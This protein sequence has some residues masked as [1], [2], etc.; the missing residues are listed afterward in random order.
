MIIHGAARG[1][2]QGGL[3]DHRALWLALARARWLRPPAAGEDLIDAARAALRAEIGPQLDEAAA[4]RLTVFAHPGC[5]PELRLGFQPR[6]DWRAVDQSVLDDASPQWLWSVYVHLSALTRRL[7]P[8]V[9]TPWDAWQH[10][11]QQHWTTA[12]FRAHCALELGVSAAE[13]SQAE[14]QGWANHWSLHDPW[15]VMAGLGLP[16]E[17]RPW[18]LTRLT[19]ESTGLN[20]HR[21]AR[22]L[23]GLKKTV[24]QLP[25]G[26]TPKV[27]PYPA[28]LLLPPDDQGITAEYADEWGHGHLHSHAFE[29]SGDDAGLRELRRFTKH[30][31]RAQQGIEAVLDTLSDDWNWRR[32]ERAHETSI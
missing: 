21:V 17:F 30:L 28:V 9:W 25:S 12:S 5:R 6:L 3:A 11:T 18:P 22:E 2:R 19:R 7:Y 24:Q 1:V 27:E 26:R 14:L 32:E 31:R 29:C 23:E 13:L 10:Y 20:Q 4:A 15:T 8:R 16:P